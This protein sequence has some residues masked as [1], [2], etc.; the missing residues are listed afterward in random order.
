[1]LALAGSG[2]SFDVGTLRPS[3]LI[4]GRVLAGPVGL[5]ALRTRARSVAPELALATRV[6]ALDR[7][8]SLDGFARLARAAVKDHGRDGGRHI[9]NG[10]QAVGRLARNSRRS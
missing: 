2:R 6:A 3:G 5:E 1:M 4:L 9:D 7:T 10:H 8:W